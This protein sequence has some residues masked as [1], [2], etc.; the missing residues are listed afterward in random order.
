M[1][2]VAQ[3]HFHSVGM[4]WDKLEARDAAI[5]D[6]DLKNVQWYINKAN[7]T[8]RR[9][10]AKSEHPLQVL[11]KLELIKDGKSTWAAILLFP[12]TSP[13]LSYTGSYPLR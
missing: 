5:T 7:E 2:E 12:R 13:T 10:I 3:M 6:I 8:G 9:N 1:Q 11:E 4:S